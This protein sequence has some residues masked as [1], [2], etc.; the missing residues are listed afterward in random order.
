V[1]E[2]VT[3]GGQYGINLPAVTSDRSNVIA[4]ALR[5]SGNGS[6]S[7]WFNTSAFS[8]PT[9]GTAGSEAN[10]ILRGPHDRRVDISLLKELPIREAATLQFRAEC[11]N[12][13]NTPNFAFPNASVSSYG[14]DGIALGGQNGGGFGTITS[15]LSSER[16]RQYQFALKLIF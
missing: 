1:T 5:A 16:P 4:T 6:L 13:S 10:N 9:L 3:P 14:P 12:I 15:T 11:F 2:S 7:E 8:A